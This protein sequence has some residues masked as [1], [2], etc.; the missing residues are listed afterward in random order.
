MRTTKLIRHCWLCFHLD[1]ASTWI[2]L[3]HY[4]GIATGLLMMWQCSIM[5]SN[6]TSMWHEYCNM[7]P[8]IPQIQIWPH[9]W[10]VNFLLAWVFYHPGDAFQEIKYYTADCNGDMGQSKLYK[11]QEEKVLAAQTYQMK[12][13]QRYHVHSSHSRH[14][15]SGTIVIKMKLGSISRQ[16]EIGPRVLPS[17]ENLCCTSH[18]FLVMV[19]VT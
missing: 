8:I 19:H 15:D 12:Y 16:N 18:S 11:M 14:L 7:Y 3:H 13:Y 1:V 6:K 10:M 4:I 5:S 17:P 2:N 9:I